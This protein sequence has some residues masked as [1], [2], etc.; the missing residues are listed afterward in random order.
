MSSSAC[1]ES[2]PSPI[3]QDL[4]PSPAGFES[5]FES[6]CLWLESQS[7]SLGNFPTLVQ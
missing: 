5:E 1:L 2:S 4:N 6:R 7:K 3:G